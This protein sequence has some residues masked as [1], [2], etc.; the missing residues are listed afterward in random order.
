MR[1]RLDPD[2]ANV[3]WQQYLQVF[4]RTAF[5]GHDLLFR[6]AALG[7]PFAVAWQQNDASSDP[8]CVFMSAEVYRQGMDAGGCGDSSH[9]TP[10]RDAALLGMPEA[11]GQYA[12][13]LYQAL[14]P[15][16]EAAEDQARRFAELCL[17]QTDD[18]RAA[19]VLAM[20][21]PDASERLRLLAHAYRKWGCLE[22]AREL[23]HQFR[24]SDPGMSVHLS[25]THL[26][27]GF[28]WSG[29]G[30]WKHILSEMMLSPWTQLSV[31]QR[32]TVFLIG[33]ALSRVVS[34]N[35]ILTV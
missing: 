8:R 3:A 33:R 2:D 9:L 31:A 20:L 19:H 23:C 32:R 22:S 28:L 30:G 13:L 15:G 6:A 7:H 35:L 24:Q 16:D 1:I 5:V 34:G 11:Q 10:L 27:D 14:D 21:S 17:K 4:F 18:A 29:D 26:R 12:Y 25:L